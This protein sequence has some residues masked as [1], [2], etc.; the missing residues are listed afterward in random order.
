[1]NNSS[2]IEKVFQEFN[3]IMAC[4]QKNIIE[5]INRTNKGELFVLNYLALQN[6]EV[7]PSELSAALQVTTGRI[8]AVLGTLEKKGYI[9]REIDKSNRRNILVTITEEGRERVEEEI[10]EVKEDFAKI[11]LEMG[12]TDT[13]E[14]L[15][16]I[17]RFL[18]LSLKYKPT[19]NEKD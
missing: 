3:E 12:E 16:L 15:R 8:S 5:N 2:F 13:L 17:K 18:E 4:D 9:I 6:T 14:L 19:F 7:L 10:K 11:F 1:M